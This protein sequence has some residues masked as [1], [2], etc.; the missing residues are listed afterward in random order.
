MI[1]ESS[2]VCALVF[3]TIA[4][5]VPCALHK[6]FPSLLKHGGAFIFLS[7]AAVA[8]LR[9]ILLVEIPANHLIRSWSFLGGLVRLIRTYPEV[10]RLIV[11][12]LVAIW[13]V[14]GI[15]LVRKDVRELVRA[16]KV[17]AGD[18]KNVIG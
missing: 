6:L 18:P 10:V 2:I 7:M 16:R 13:A 5:L 14:I 15:W 8:T 17:A 9:L 1:S 11:G 4:L 12:L 3:F